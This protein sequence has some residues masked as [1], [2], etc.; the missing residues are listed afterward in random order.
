[1]T[2]FRLRPEYGSKELLIEFIYFEKETVD[3][4]GYK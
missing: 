1:M 2:K 3:F 4:E